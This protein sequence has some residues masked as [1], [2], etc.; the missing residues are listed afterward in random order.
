MSSSEQTQASWE[1]WNTLYQSV[2]KHI[3]SGELRLA[4]AEVESFQPESADTELRSRILSEKAGLKSDLGDLSGAKKDWLLARSLIGPSFTRYVQE[5]S[6]A[7]LCVKTENTSEALSWYRAAFQTCLESDCSGG[8]ALARFLRL[9]G[10]SLSDQDQRLCSAVVSHSWKLLK[11]P[12]NPNNADLHNMARI[13]TEAES[14]S[15]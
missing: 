10:E 6:L 4:L 5:I 1:M 11:L 13:L 14:K 9:A 12:G 8:G 7:D 3:S 15:L 2:A